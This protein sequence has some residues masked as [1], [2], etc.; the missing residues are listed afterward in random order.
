MKSR[1]LLVTIKL[2]VY[3]NTETYFRKYILHSTA[4][5]TFYGVK[6]QKS[7]IYQL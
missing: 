6:T 2:K 5:G 4:Y 7:T 1:S 3:K